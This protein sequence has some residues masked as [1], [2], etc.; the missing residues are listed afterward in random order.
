MGEKAKHSVEILPVGLTILVPD[1]ETIMSVALASGWRWPNVCGGEAA[2]GVCVLEIQQGMENASAI[3]R[4]EVVRLAFIRKADKPG[5]RLACQLR[6]SGPM[7][8]LKRGARPLP[9]QI[10]TPG[11]TGAA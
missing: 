1:G 2:C 3:G 11:E 5:S 7:Q 4:D 10:E 9:E 8:V 6:V